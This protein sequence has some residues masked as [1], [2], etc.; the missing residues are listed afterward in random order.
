MNEFQ[1]LTYMLSKKGRE[2]GADDHEIM[3]KLGMDE[4]KDFQA[5][6]QLL[7]S[8][9]EYISV[10]GLKVQQNPLNNKWFL[11]YS[12]NID[13]MIKINPFQG[14]TRIATTLVAILIAIMCQD[15][16]EKI[17][18]IEQI[19]RIRKKQN[20][21]RDLKDL[22]ELGLIEIN[23]NKI[24][25]TDNVG[26]YI[27]IPEFIIKIKETIDENREETLRSESPV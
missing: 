20:I 8:Y 2:V 24:T 23:K 13:K 12:D 25:I 21:E 26:F 15:E 4:D 9:S 6:H 3:K 16:N 1:I 10:I 7:K 19:R 11:T 27:D 14:R 5:L 17:I 22:E 18:T